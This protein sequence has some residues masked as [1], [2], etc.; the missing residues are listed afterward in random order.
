VDS[1]GTI[2][3]LLAITRSEIENNDMIFVSEGIVGIQKTLYLTK[4]NFKVVF[5]SEKEMKIVIAKSEMSLPT[6][7]VK[8]YIHNFLV[9][10]EVEAIE[11]KT[12]D[13]EHLKPL[14]DSINDEILFDKR[15]NT[16]KGYIYGL[17]TEM[18]FEKSPEEI[19]IKR[20]I[21]TLINAHAEFKNR[22]DLSNR[23]TE[24]RYSRAGNSP[25]SSF[26]NNV[27]EKLKELEA[28]VFSVFPKKDITYN[29]VAS[30]IFNQVPQLFGSLDEATLYVRHKYI[31][32][33]LF[34]TDHYRLLKK[35]VSTG[36]SKDDA[37]FLMENLHESFKSSFS[38]S[39]SYLPSRGTTR[40]NDDS[41]KE[42]IFKLESLISQ[43]YSVNR[44][45]KVINFQDILYHPLLNEIELASDFGY[46]ISETDKKEYILLANIIFRR[47]KKE[48]GEAR[49][50]D[51]LE[52][53]KEGAQTHNKAV[54]ST[55]TLL[56]KYLNNELDVYSLDKVISSV[57]KNFVAFIFN[58][59][60]IEKLE[61]YLEANNIKNK[62]MA[63][64]FWCGFNGFANIGSNF[65]KP[66]FDINAQ[67]MQDSLDA[68]LI[69][70]RATIPKGEKELRKMQQENI[71]EKEDLEKKN[72]IE[73]FEK[74]IKD[75]FKLTF[76]E[77]TGILDLK[78]DTEKLKILKAKHD[79]ESK[80]G[81]SILSSYVKF[82]KSPHLF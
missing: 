5:F 46:N 2:K 56:Y 72:R 51:L 14:S 43:Y 3:F 55:D 8:K 30:L 24:A 71:P 34:D 80:A 45:Y 17:V 49:K 1:T 40:Y 12:S 15:F 63:Y 16:L 62:W 53:V 60:S 75:K 78:K 52:I 48:K 65:L 82:T 66:V 44:K 58:P 26:F 74:C 61:K 77:L 7:P 47:P 4:E 59:D 41:F 23:Q 70:L 33:I 57:M 27:L 42:S 35:K 76:E 37:N 73:F 25:L 38:S 31:D 64:S 50:I 13:I 21:Q 68:F 29:E 69:Q 67:E 10:D 36:N 19:K 54:I 11:F 39:G 9:I 22:I 32:S 18:A 6:K 20:G 28:Q 81:K 79:I